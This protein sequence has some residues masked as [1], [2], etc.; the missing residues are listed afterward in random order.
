[1]EET[2]GF[3]FSHRLSALR[4]GQHNGKSS[5]AGN[6]VAYQTFLPLTSGLCCIVRENGNSQEVNTS[7][8]KATGCA[9]E[10]ILYGPLINF[11]HPCDVPHF[12]SLLIYN[13]KSGKN[14]TGVS[15]RFK[16]KILKRSCGQVCVA[17]QPGQATTFYFTLRKA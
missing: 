1:M 15:Y 17:S 12:N 3:P 10:E 16:K 7:F 6:Q 2:A 13:N 8:L 14:T 11:A 5:F 9:A 4:N